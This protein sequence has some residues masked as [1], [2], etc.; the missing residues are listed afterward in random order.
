MESRARLA[1]QSPRSTFCWRIC[2]HRRHRPN[3][4]EVYTAHL[5]LRG[6]PSAGASVTTAAIGQTINGQ[7]SAGAFVCAAA[8]GQTLARCTQPRP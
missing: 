5:N 6:Q 7:P 4:N 3:S 2:H 8:I 1:P